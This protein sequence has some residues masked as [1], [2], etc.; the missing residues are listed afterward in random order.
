MCG[1]RESCGTQS[2]ICA[3]IDN[4]SWI[5]LR[6]TQAYMFCPGLFAEAAEKGTPTWKADPGHDS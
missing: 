1:R 5:L 6:C 2:R 4:H 3:Q